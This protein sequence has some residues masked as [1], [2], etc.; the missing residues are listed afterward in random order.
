M[1]ILSLKNSDFSHFDYNLFSV[2]KMVFEVPLSERFG[3]L[4][5]LK[6]DAIP[7]IFLSLMFW[8]LIRIFFSSVLTLPLFAPFSDIRALRM[9]MS[10]FTH[11]L[12]VSIGAFLVLSGTISEI[13]AHSPWGFDFPSIFVY[14]LSI[15]YFICDI[16]DCIQSWKTN[17]VFIVHHFFSI[18][19]LSFLIFVCLFQLTYSS[20]AFGFSKGLFSLAGK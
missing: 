14:C 8:Y 1:F 3:A 6:L 18:T 10:S 4:D 16:F 17:G 2:E 9:E 7:F 11:S 12:L 13:G 20:A 15:G 19:L 5:H